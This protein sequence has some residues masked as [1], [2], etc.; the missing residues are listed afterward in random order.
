[1]DEFYESK[2]KN[3]IIITM[4]QKLSTAKFFTAWSR[5][6]RYYY[7]LKYQG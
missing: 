3:K 1:M 4:K 7:I 6:V 5:R 2:E